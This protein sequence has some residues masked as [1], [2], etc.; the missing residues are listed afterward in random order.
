MPVVECT[1]LGEPAL[2]GPLDLSP[3]LPERRIVD[4]GLQPAQ[5]VQVGQPAVADGL[6]E[7]RPQSRV[8]QR[9]EASRRHAVGHIAE[10]LR[11]QLVEVFEHTGFQQLRVQRRHTVDRVAADGGQVRHPHALAVVLADER[12]P[13]DPV[14]VAGEPRPHLVEEAVVDLVDD[15]QV[16]RQRLAEDAQR[17]GLQRLGQQRV[18]GV[19]EGLDGD[20]PRL[21]PAQV[22]VVDEQPHQL[23]HR[24]RRVGVVELDGPL[25]AA[26][27][28]AAARPGRCGCAGCPAAST[29]RRSTA[30][31]AAA[32]CPHRVRRWGRAPWR[33]S[34]RRPPPRRPCRSRRC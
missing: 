17:P 23:G 25:L 8:G 28:T 27:P 20:L 21:V 30:A 15:L 6:V 14:L 26:A 22:V 33:R 7:Q 11:P 34:R 32:A 3:A 1:I 31:A 10:P 13:R 24:D 12:H 4:V 16:P 2:V 18:V 29:T 19:G 9:Q 5:L